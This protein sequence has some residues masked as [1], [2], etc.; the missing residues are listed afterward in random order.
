MPQEGFL[1]NCNFLNPASRY[2]DFVGPSSPHS[3]RSVL[4]FLQ[5]WTTPKAPLKVRAG[6]FDLESPPQIPTKVQRRPA[7]VFIE[8]KS[9]VFPFLL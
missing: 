7:L 2:R 6:H 5:K 9:L 8:E 1:M 3:L 4:F